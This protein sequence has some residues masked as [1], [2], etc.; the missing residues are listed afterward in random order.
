MFVTREPAKMVHAQKTNATVWSV[1]TTQPVVVLIAVLASSQLTGPAFALTERCRAQLYQ[2]VPPT[3][4]V[5]VV[6]SARFSLAAEIP[7]ASRP[8]VLI[9]L[10]DLLV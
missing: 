7:Y 3:K 10:Q 5:E 9:L 4:T 6:Q 1:V 2:A 8:F